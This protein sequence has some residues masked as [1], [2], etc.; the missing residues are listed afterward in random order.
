MKRDILGA[1]GVKE[2]TDKNITKYIARRIKYYR[3]QK[4]LTQK[5]LGGMVGIKHNTIS[6]KDLN[7]RP[8]APKAGVIMSLDLRLVT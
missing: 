7:L 6:S 1:E 8:P 5:E 4:G 3:E 2:L